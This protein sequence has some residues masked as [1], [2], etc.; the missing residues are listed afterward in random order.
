[1][2]HHKLNDALRRSPKHLC[3]SRFW[4]PV[5][6]CIPCWCTQGCS[7]VPWVLPHP[8]TARAAGHQTLSVVRPT[9]MHEVLDTS[10]VIK[11]ARFRFVGPAKWTSLT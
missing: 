7:P 11:F 4:E 9:S 10:T 8:A 6:A 1:M 5:S 3:R 2:Y